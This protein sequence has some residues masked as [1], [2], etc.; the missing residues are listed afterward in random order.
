MPQH[1]SAS[2]FSPQDFSMMSRALK[3]A[4]RGIY[5]T[6]P[7]PNVGCVI[8]R[9]GVIV[10][11]GYHHRAGE[12]HAEVHAMRMAGDKAEGATAYVTLEPCSHY[13]RTPPCAE[14]LIKAKVARV[15]CAMEDPNPKV[16]GRGIQ[17]LRE[18]GVEV[19]VGLLENDAIELNRG[20]IKFMQTGMPFIQLKMAASLDGQSALSNGKSQWITSPQAR[21]DVQCYRAQSGGILS[22]SKTVMDDNASLNVRWDDLPQT[23]QA[24]YELT[25]VRQPARVI[26]DRQQKL[27]DD[28]KLFSTEGERIIVSSE[29][30]VCPQLDQSGKI[31]LAATLKAVA[32]QHNINHLWVEAGATLASSL[33]K[34]NLVDELIVYLAPKLMGSD[35]RG[36]IG[37]LGLTEMAQVIDLNITDVRMVGRDIRITATVVRKEI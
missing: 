5:T 16:A 22:T 27:S 35:G 30:D 33:I 13:G 6:A 9:D 1:T 7:N 3:L 29:G 36:L 21:Q 31:D 25:E 12:P 20:F 23:V 18:A 17:M 32:T 19:Q 37:A 10:G 24:H 14:G 8:V 2:P 26:L 11:E 34:A 4:R 28:L 15:V